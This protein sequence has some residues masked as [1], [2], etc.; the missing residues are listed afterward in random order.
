MKSLFE[1]LPDG[2]L[3]SI[4]G[5]LPDIVDDLVVMLLERDPTRFL[6]VHYV[7]VVGTEQAFVRFELD[8]E[9]FNVAFDLEFL[10][11]MRARGFELP[12]QHSISHVSLS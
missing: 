3:E 8:R 11:A 7:P 12:R 5:E 2:V 4:A 10:A 6:K 9:A 1:S